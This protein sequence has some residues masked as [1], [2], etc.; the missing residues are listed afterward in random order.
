MEAALTDLT[1]Y[2]GFP[3]PN[4]RG[5]IVLDN[6]T[7]SDPSVL[8]WPQQIE[9]EI[10]GPIPPDLSLDLRERNKHSVSLERFSPKNRAILIHDINARVTDPTF[11]SAFPEAK[12]Y[13]RVSLPG[14]D[15]SRRAALLRFGAGPTGG[16]EAISGTYALLKT[17][18][19]WKV[20]W[21]RIAYLTV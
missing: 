8:L 16:A 11:R 17:G 7:L 13:V 1:Q 14:Y 10:G 4:S 6:K 3:R 15:R 9:H 19:T 18:G 21:R 12:A 20:Q 2:G 5:T